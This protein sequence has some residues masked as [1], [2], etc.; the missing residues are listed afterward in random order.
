M[1]ACAS[2]LLSNAGH[3]RGVTVLCDYIDS[4]VCRS[5]FVS[6]SD[7][8]Q[9]ARYDAPGWAHEGRFDYCPEHVQGLSSP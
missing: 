4:E 5:R 9:I 2:S 3:V 8:P 6:G 1:T 7:S